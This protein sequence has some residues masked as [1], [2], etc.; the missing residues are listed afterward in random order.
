[1][2]FSDT[3]EFDEDEYASK[4]SDEKEYPT[5][6]LKTQEIVKCRQ[7]ISAGA[8]IGGG[9]G[10]APFTF[11]LSL[12]GTAYGARRLYI[13][14]KKLELIQAELK[15]RSVVLHKPT[16]RDF[17]IPFGTSI[18]TLGLG[19]GVDALAAHATSQVATHVIADHGTRAIGEA[20]QSPGSFCHGVTDG[21]SLQMHELGNVVTGGL[22]HATAVA[23]MDSS[24]IISGAAYMNPG[25]AVGLAAGTAAAQTMEA[26]LA[27]FASGKI[28]LR[29]VD[30]VLPNRSQAFSFNTPPETCQRRK[31]LPPRLCCDHCGELIDTAKDTSYRRVPNLAYRSV[32]IHDK[33]AANA[34]LR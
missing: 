29:T 22:Q 13:A 8:S 1:M 14:K 30:R 25:A 5:H 4:I 31:N 3:F 18:V 17:L 11:G 27:K 12:V 26:Q 15:R 9:V 20:V 34:T 16:K 32:L 2:G 33:I 7:H 28:A 19:A 10:L 24:Y 21:I 23:N 6:I